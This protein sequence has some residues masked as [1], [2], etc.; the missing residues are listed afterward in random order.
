MKRV[1]FYDDVPIF[2]GHQVTAIA[3]AEGLAAAG[4]EVL[5]AFPSTNA[6][7][8][9]AWRR[10][11]GAVQ[12]MPI[13]VRLTR[14]QPFLAPFGI[15]A[16]PVRRLIADVAPD[17]VVAV[18]GTIVQ[19]NRAVE[20]SRRLRVPVVSF[21]PMG[22]HFAPGQWAQAAVARVLER[23]H[24]RRP[25]AFITV[26][27]H[28]RRELLAG[29]ARA[30]IHV[31][32]CGADLRTL[33][34]VPR[35]EARRRL[36]LS[37]FAAGIIGRVSFGTKGHDTLL[38][39]LPSMP[40]VQLLVVG[41]GPDDARLDAMTAELGLSARVR[42]LP[43]RREMSDVYSALD[44]VVIPSRFEGLPLVAFEAME[45]ELP[46]V[47]ADMGAMREVLPPSWLFPVGDP[48][49]LAAT[50]R[51]L[52]RRDLAPIVAANRERVRRELNAAAFGARFTA[53]LRTICAAR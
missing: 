51:E 8:A 41:D 53:A 22:V 25:D 19:S 1:L 50:M 36:G 3:A 43:W 27:E 26:S 39:A 38:R 37:G 2:G 5:S 15:A 6:R 16:T 30:P 4:V 11:E 17:V 44:M 24:Y 52:R 33:H 45:L 12:L 40:D 28:S 21:V 13:D 47:A 23:Y 7:L 34:R 10:L 42:R 48:A 9:E 31:V 32:Y 18:Q 29:G 20:Q 49:A 14:W 46:I 35:G